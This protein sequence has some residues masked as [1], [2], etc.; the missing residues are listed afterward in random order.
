MKFI[1]MWTKTGQEQ[2]Y[3]DRF[4]NIVVQLRSVIVKEY[5]ETVAG[6]LKDGQTI[7][8]ALSPWRD[9][10]RWAV[11]SSVVDNFGSI[12]N[13]AAILAGWR[14][15]CDP[16]MDKINLVVTEAEWAKKDNWVDPLGVSAMNNITRTMIKHFFDV[17]LL[18]YGRGMMTYYTDNEVRLTPWWNGPTIDTVDFISPSLYDPQ[19]PEV[20]NRS[21]IASAELAAEYDIPMA[22]FIG[23][24]LKS[25]GG[26]DEVEY[27]PETEFTRGLLLKHFEEQIKVVGLYPTPDFDNP[28]YMS[29]LDWLQKGM[30]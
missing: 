7:T 11:D 19:K 13:Y 29:H 18:M 26:H 12:L 23:I 14:V 20:E 27:A 28:V 21:M 24:G 16:Y 10:A 15:I 4:D 8:L 22:P 1:S 25:L 6:M 9:D 3:L 17:P 2:A 30:E 5:L